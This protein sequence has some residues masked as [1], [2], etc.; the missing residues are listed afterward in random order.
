MTTSETTLPG[1]EAP[2]TP[3]AP[4]LLKG[5]TPLL[6]ELRDDLVERAKLPGVEEA[7]RAGH[8]KE[9]E[10]QRTADPFEIWCYGRATQVAAAW[11]LSVVF[12][13][14][15]EDRALIERRRIAG[16]GAEDSQQQFTTLAPFLSARDYL[17]AV[18]RE[19]SRLPGAEGLFDARH[20]PVWVLGPSGQMAAKLVEF[21]RQKDDD[22]ALRWQFGGADSRFLGDLYQDLDE[23]V[24]KRYALLQT[25]DFIESFI[26]DETLTPAIKTFGLAEVKLIDPTCGSGHFLLGAFGRLFAAWQ[27]AEPATDRQVLAQRAL[28]QVHGADLNPYAVAIA[29]FR[30]TL[31]FLTAAGLE[32]IAKAPPL[33][34]NVCVA[35]S[36]LHGTN[37][38]QTAIASAPQGRFAW[39]V[40]PEFKAAWNLDLFAFE[41]TREPDELLRA[42]YH[43]VVGNPPYITEKDRARRDT[44]RAL[45]PKSAAGKYALAAPFTERFFQLAERGGYV[46]LINANSFMKREFGKKLIQEYLPSVELTQVVDTSG[47][48]IPGHGTPTV[49]LFGRQQRAGESRVLAVL[50]KR[51]EPSTPDDPS[52]G[53]VW[54]SIRDHYRDVG[55]ENDYVSVAEVERDVFGKHPWSLGGGGAAELKEVLEHRAHSRLGD[56]GEI[57][58][59]GMTNA[60]DCMLLTPEVGRRRGVEPDFVKPLAIGEEIRDWSISPSTHVLYPYKWPDQLLEENSVRGLFRYLWPYRTTMSARATFEGGT[61]RTAGL[62]WWKWHQVAFERLRTPLTITFAFVATHNHFVLDRGGKVFNRSAP[63]IKLPERATEE[64]HLAL[65]GYLNSSTACFW[66]KQ[67]CHRKSSAS[68]K[69][70][71]DP[72][73]AAYEFAGTA[74][75]QLPLPSLGELG[76]AE[77]VDVLQ[78]LAMDRSAWTS[79]ITFTSALHAGLKTIEEVKAAAAAGWARYDKQTAQCVYLQEEIDWIVYAAFGLCSQD[80]VCTECKSDAQ[81]TL[82]SRPFEHAAGYSAGVSE[83]ARRADEGKAHDHGRPSH[84]SQRIALLKRPEIG[85]IETTEFK[86]QWRDTER[87][88]DQREF[89]IAAV[90]EWL[91]IYVAQLVETAVSALP[92]CQS[93]RAVVKA[94]QSMAG[95]PT[96][97]VADVLGEDELRLIERVAHNDSVSYVAANRYTKSGIEKRLCWQRVWSLQRQQD[98]GQELDVPVPPKY[99]S[100]DFAKPEYWSLRGKLDVPKERFISYPGAESDS[101]PSPLIGWAGWDHL[102]QATALSGLYQ[103]RKD[104]DGWLADRLT[105]LL[106]GLWELVPWIKQWHNE[107]DANFGGLKLGDFYETFVKDECRKFDLT[108]ADLEAWRPTPSR[109]GRAANSRAKPRPPALTPEALLAAVKRLQNGDE[110]VT[111]KALADDLGVTSAVVGKTAKPLVEAGTLAELSKRPKRFHLSSAEKG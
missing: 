88:V 22:G 37:W 53:E 12:V 21:F 106:A 48:Y 95:T 33:P 62:P 102:Q 93:V 54:A 16:S 5:L 43:A 99:A 109:K 46:G 111:Q 100:T 6:A 84:W 104:E 24:R 45:Y 89:R 79:G 29:R 68:Q 72:A 27:E 41:D 32:R 82:G 57:G 30:L 91:E 36:L 2:K 77:F 1:T 25:P 103:Q 71:T 38:Q 4:A 66:M 52:N 7:L 81:A 80:A 20:N 67:V 51:G 49:L 75:L 64:D 94:T 107:P 40:D 108:T 11:V 98:A 39:E 85:L 9:K 87:N 44:Y 18:F 35:D 26:L 13:R 55:F 63:I 96:A 69:H 92:N 56:L 86:R 15:L 78:Q 19:L 8:A 59:L 14:T 28:A 90:R 65:L 110:G 73:R 97:V 42:R 10:S 74:L 101:D 3:D 23:G 61:Y 70:H 76:I 83:R 17:L 105:P 58:V 60:D 34:L 31:A 47:A 50:G